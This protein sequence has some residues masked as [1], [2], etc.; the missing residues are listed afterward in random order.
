MKINKELIKKT[1]LTAIMLLVGVVVFAQLKDFNGT[2]ALNEAGKKINEMGK[3][4]MNIASVA[5][6][7]I[8]AILIAWNYFKRGKGDGQSNDSLASLLWGTGIVIILFQ[9]VKVVFFQ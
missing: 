7:I 5:T 8:G 9:V 3:I 1:S 6:G 4:V 2:S